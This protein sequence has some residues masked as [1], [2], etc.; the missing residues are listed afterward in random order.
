MFQTCSQA[1]G[2]VKRSNRIRLP[3][4]EY[5]QSGPIGLSRMELNSCTCRNTLCYVHVFHIMLQAYYNSK[6]SNHTVS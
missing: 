4:M 2:R 5:D 6:K 1:W 3:Y